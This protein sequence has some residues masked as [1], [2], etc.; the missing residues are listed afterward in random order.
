M[1]QNQNTTTANNHQRVIRIKFHDHFLLFYQSLSNW[2]LS[3]GYFG[4]WGHALVAVAVVA[5]FK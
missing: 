2:L 1:K 3:R 4:S 5:R